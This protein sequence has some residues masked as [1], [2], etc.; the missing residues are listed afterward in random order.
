MAYLPSLAQV[1]LRLTAFGESVEILE[2]DIEEQIQKC[3]PLISK[4]VY[5]TENIDLEERVGQ[6]L[7]E[8]NLKISCAESCT[9][10]YLSHL[11]TSIPGS[12]DYFNGSYV[13][14]SYEIKEKALWVDRELLEAKGAVSEEVVIQMADNIRNVFNTDIGV[15]LSGIAGPGGGTEDKPVGTVWIAVSSAAG[16]KARKYVFTKDRILNI[17][18]SSMVALNMIRRA[19]EKL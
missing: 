9:G 16:T 17:K 2:K 15:A 8:K 10:G 18:L 3:L 19:I 7:R 5:S 14:Y 1:K 12:S 4:Y 11:L 6:M 13:A